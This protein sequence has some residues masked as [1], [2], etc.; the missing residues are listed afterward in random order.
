MI[1]NGTRAVRYS[2]HLQKTSGAVLLGVV[3]PW[4]KPSLEEIRE[5]Y[6]LSPNSTGSEDSSRTDYYKLLNCLKFSVN[7]RG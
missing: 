4:M 5:V 2:K 6:N 3:D 1:A 7:G